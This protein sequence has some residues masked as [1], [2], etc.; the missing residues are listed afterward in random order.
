MIYGQLYQM[1]VTHQYENLF[2]KRKRNLQN[3]K[4]TDLLKNI[5][6]LRVYSYGPP[7]MAVQ[8]QDD[9]HE[10]TFSSYVRIR[11]AVLKTYL[12]RWTIGRSDERGSGISVQP[13]RY[14]NHDDIYVYI[15]M[16]VCVC[17]CA[18]ACVCVCVCHS[19]HSLFLYVSIMY[20]KGVDDQYKSYWNGLTSAYIT[21]LG[22]A[23]RKK[24]KCYEH[25]QDKIE[26]L[27]ALIWYFRTLT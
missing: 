20:Q 13:V 4:M 19:P 15:Y 6:L 1:L 10:H 11:D 23:S 27:S 2:G 12:G 26:T 18:R 21:Y 24:R 7:H 3:R 22:L 16:C 14:D 17:V 8:K 9:Q 5:F 25:Q